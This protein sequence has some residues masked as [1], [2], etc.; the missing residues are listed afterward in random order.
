[1]F[2]FRMTARYI[3]GIGAVSYVSAVIVDALNG[4]PFY[5]LGYLSF[6][7]S[8]FVEF[9]FL[10]LFLLVTAFNYLFTKTFWSVFKIEYYFLFLRLGLFV[11][12]G[13]IYFL[14]DLLK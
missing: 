2:Y 6:M 14:V 4:N 8:L 11:L 13:L 3:F 10:L 1:M 7:Y 12:I 5:G 9:P